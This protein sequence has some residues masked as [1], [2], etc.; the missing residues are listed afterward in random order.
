MIFFYGTQKMI[1][2]KTLR[3]FFIFS[4]HQRGA[5]RVKVL[6]INGVQCFFKPK[7]SS[8]H[9]ILCYFG[10][11]C[12]CGR[13]SIIAQS[14]VRSHWSRSIIVCVVNMKY[15]ILYNMFWGF[16]IH[17]QTDKWLA[18]SLIRTQG[19]ACQA[20]NTG[21]WF[22]AAQ[23]VLHWHTTVCIRSCAGIILMEQAVRWE[24][25]NNCTL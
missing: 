11:H 21:G 3:V 23:I 2:R 7:H 13:C 1:F 14:I 25:C 17:A 19:E 10:E 22:P 15:G 4:F 9:F 8:K 18:T 12:L 24:A 16:S 6:E 5:E 20:V